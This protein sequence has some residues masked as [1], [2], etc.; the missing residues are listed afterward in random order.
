MK[1]QTTVSDER[2]W[3]LFI[4]AAI[5]ERWRDIAQSAEELVERLEIR[6]NDFSPASVRGLVNAV[7]AGPGRRQPK[8]R[9]D[10]LKRYLA[11]R[12]HRAGED[13]PWNRAVGQIASDLTSLETDVTDLVDVIGEGRGLD[14]L[15]PEERARLIREVHLRL[16]EVF[17]DA[18][19]SYYEMGRT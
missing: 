19:T 5:Q 11:W 3:K 15:E 18:L 14:P 1:R 13:N 7:G 10:S 6:S 12:K 17:I 2:L 8:E 9:L 4:E 16:C